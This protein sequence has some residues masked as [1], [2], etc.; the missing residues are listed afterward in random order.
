MI[1]LELAE[2]TIWNGI[3]ILL[4]CYAALHLLVWE[5]LVEKSDTDAKGTFI[6]IIAICALALVA[7][8]F[9]GN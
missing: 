4:W 7:A 2:S 3:A 8:K 9:G 5:F 6:K 1:T